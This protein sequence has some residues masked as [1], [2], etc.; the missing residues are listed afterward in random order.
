MKPIGYKIDELAAYC[1]RQLGAPTWNVELT[2]QHVV[3]CI[4][5]ALAFYSQW[6]PRLLYGSI[7]LNSGIT[8]YLEGVDI[9]QGIVQVD[10]VEVN[11]TPTELYYGN[12]ITNAPLMMKGMDEYDTYQRWR[13]TW[14]RVTSSRPDWLYDFERKCLWIHNPIDRYKAGILAYG[15]WTETEG[16]NHNGAVWVKEYSLNKARYLLGDIW[17]KYSGAIPGPIKDIQLDTSKRDKAEK[18]IEE[19]EALLRN[20]QELTPITIDA[21]IGVLIPAAALVWQS[22]TCMS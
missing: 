3:D 13:K 6:K 11:P 8:K 9:G 15:T 7:S 5:D 18:K 19:L 17:A 1:M 22:I 14:M 21:I 16:L 12:L 2:K 20:S 4:N 10:F